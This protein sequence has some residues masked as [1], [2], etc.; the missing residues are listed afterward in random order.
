MRASETRLRALQEGQQHY[1]IPLFQRPYSWQRN[2]RTGFRDFCTYLREDEAGD[3]DLARLL[4]PFA[5]GSLRHL[6][7]DTT[8]EETDVIEWWP[9]SHRRNED[10]A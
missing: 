9:G 6:L 4:R 10:N 3:P 2:E 8:P 7:I 5:T 1:V